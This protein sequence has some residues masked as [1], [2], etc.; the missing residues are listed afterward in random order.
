MC[1]LVSDCK[2]GLYTLL[3]YYRPP[4]TGPEKVLL[5]NSSHTVVDVKSTAGAAAIC[6]MEIKVYYP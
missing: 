6:N 1:V 4:D 2:S 5:V 3:S